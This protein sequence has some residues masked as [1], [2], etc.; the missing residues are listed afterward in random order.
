MVTVILRHYYQYRRKNDFYIGIL[1]EYQNFTMSYEH[2]ELLKTMDCY[3]KS[4]SEFWSDYKQNV[5]DCDNIMSY[6]MNYF[7]FI[8]PKVYIKI[9]LIGFQGVGKTTFLKRLT[10]NSFATNYV[11]TDAY[12]ITN[13]VRDNVTYEFY[14]FGGLTYDAYYRIYG[15]ELYEQFHLLFVMFDDDQMSRKYGLK[16]LR[17]IKNAYNIPTLKIRNK[18]EKVNADFEFDNGD[19]YLNIS[20]KTGRGVEEVLKQ[21]VIEY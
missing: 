10:D 3:S 6:V 11:A 20:T 8:K 17:R 4:N 2:N 21:I 14:D 18:S 9:G 19:G 13:V 12:S 15:S 7:T 1:Y 16:W 5:I